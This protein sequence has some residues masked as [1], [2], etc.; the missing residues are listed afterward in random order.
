[1][2]RVFNACP[3]LYYPLIPFCRVTF[4]WPAKWASRFPKHFFYLVA[5]S[6]SPPPQNF[7]TANA[8]NAT[9]FPQDPQVSNTV[10]IVASSATIV[11]KVEK[12]ASAI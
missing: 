4:S 10:G 11:L 6:E 5:T 7:P 3:N 2:Q 9:S 8:T 1:M 12:S